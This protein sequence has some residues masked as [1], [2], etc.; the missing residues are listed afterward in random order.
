MANPD[1]KPS[2]TSSKRSII[3]DCA[4]DLFAAR[5]YDAIGVQ[6]LVNQAGIT[7]PTLYYY[8]GSKRG[9]LETLI[10]EKLAPFIDQLSQA[11]AYSGDLPFTLQRVVEAYFQFA[12]REPKFYQLFLSLS[13]PVPDNEANQM[14]KPWITTQW[15][16][17]ETLFQQA[18]QDHGNMRG[19]HHHY[20]TIFLS[21]LNG[22]LSMIL[23]QGVKVDDHTVW[24]VVQQFSH[25]IYS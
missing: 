21:I 5:G 10:Q 9:L 25:G 6:E 23:Q 18:G 7:K 8:F 2:S 14:M 4:L 15:Q 20:A 16:L 12:R 13:Y 17:L 3:L 1:S 22:Y 19:R 24:Q 11:T